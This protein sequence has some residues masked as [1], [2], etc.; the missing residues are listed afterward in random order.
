MKGKTIRIFGWI[1]VVFYSL[2]ALVTFTILVFENLNFTGFSTFTMFFVMAYTGWKARNFGL[3][4]CKRTNIIKVASKLSLIFGCFFIILAPFMLSS[5]YGL[6]DSY[7][8]IIVLFVMFLPAI[9][10]SITLLTKRNFK[11]GEEK[12]LN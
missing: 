11:V 7:E 9:V 5:S 10:S 2:M 12:V 8:P 1:S 6:A 4:H 3:I